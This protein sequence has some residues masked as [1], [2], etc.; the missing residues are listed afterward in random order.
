MMVSTRCNLVTS[1]AQTRS[2]RFV[3]RLLS[4]I[5]GGDLDSGVP[6]RFIIMLYLIPP[7]VRSGDG[8]GHLSP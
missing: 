6:T 2:G 1:Y 8:T 5:S 4:K 3:G 7:A